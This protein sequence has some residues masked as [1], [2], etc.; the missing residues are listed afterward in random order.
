[1]PTVRQKQIL[2]MTRLVFP[3]AS[4][5]RRPPKVDWN[6]P[7]DAELDKPEI[8]PEGAYAAR[9]IGAEATSTNTGKAML[10]LKFQT[11][12]GK[13]NGRLVYSPENEKAKRMWFLQLRNMQVG[14]KFF[15]DNPEMDDVALACLKAECLIRVGHREFEGNQF[16]DVVFIDE[17]PRPNDE[18]A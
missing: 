12:E 18:G 8:H 14:P 7:K 10:K 4:I 3:D 15:E 13:V 6:A 1:M 17:I 2:K 9:V 5:E 16:P 11:K